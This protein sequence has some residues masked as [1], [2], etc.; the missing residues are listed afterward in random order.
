MSDLKSGKILCI[1][2]ASKMDL[3]KGISNQTSMAQIL[4]RNVKT[5]F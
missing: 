4:V 2:T 1:H 3:T 5:L